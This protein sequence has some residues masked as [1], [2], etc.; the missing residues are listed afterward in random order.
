MIGES[1]VT[2][3]LQFLSKKG[4]LFDLHAK[5]SGLNKIHLNLDRKQ[6]Y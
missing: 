3:S 6:N 5:F 4:D 1:P 2:I